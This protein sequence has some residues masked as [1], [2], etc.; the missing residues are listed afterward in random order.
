MRFPACSLSSHVRTCTLFCLC[1]II[2]FLSF[3]FS[4]GGACVAILLCRPASL[5]CVRIR[6]CVCVPCAYVCM[7]FQESQ[8]LDSVSLLIKD[9]L[10]GE[11]LMIDNLS[12]SVFHHYSSPPP[13]CKD[14]K[15]HPP[16]VPAP[17][18][19]P[20]PPP[21][22]SPPHPTRSAHA[23]VRNAPGSAISR[24]GAEWGRDPAVLPRGT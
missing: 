23:T 17:P 18:P 9:T 16:E 14:C 2:F 3:L 6:V 11:M 8:W 10:E 1:C 12:G 5:V 21:S 15:G 13:L 19:P 22:P 4:F 7:W 20:A 24:R